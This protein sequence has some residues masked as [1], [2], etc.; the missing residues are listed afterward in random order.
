MSATGE[1]ALLLSPRRHGRND[2]RV[3]GTLARVALGGGVPRQVAEGVQEADFGAAGRDLA[4]VRE[5]EGKSAPR[6]PRGP[7]ALQQRRLDQP[8]PRLARRRAGGL[9]RA[10]PDR[11]RPRRRGGGRPPGPAA[12]AGRRVRDRLGPGLVGA[13]GD[14]IWFTAS[15]AWSLR[16][17]YAVNLDGRERLVYQ[18]LATLTLHDIARDG[19][20][21]LHP[22][23]G[24]LG[25]HGPGARRAGRAR[26]GL[27]RRLGRR[28]PVAR[29]AHARPVR[30]ARGRRPPLLDLPAAHRRLARR[31]PGRRRRLGPVAR[32][33]VGP[34][35]PLRRRRLGAPAHVAAHRRRRAA[36]AGRR[37]AGPRERRP[38]SATASGC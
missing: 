17:L 16:A 2:P 7:G 14:E 32:R 13:T 25:A 23:R 10:P 9:P 20:V 12:R 34:V 26:P 21:L 29:R 36:G 4:V 6:V 22:D 31:A 24:A 33:Q 15:R 8:P 27:A 18:A 30:G 3:H 38:G 1:L 35:D 11:R 28:R 19:G 37:P 5:S